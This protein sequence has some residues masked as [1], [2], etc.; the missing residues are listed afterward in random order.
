[1]G[2]TIPSFRIVL[3]M[4]KEEWKPFRTAL[5]KSGIRQAFLATVCISFQ[6]FFLELFQ[7]SLPFL[8]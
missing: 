3:E 5:D 4:E 1:M 2:R 6:T 8:G 7:L